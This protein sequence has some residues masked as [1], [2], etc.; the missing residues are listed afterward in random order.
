M[1]KPILI[2][3]GGIGGMT[4]AL[5]LLQAGFAVEIHEQADR[6]GDVGAGIT[7]GKTASRG[8]YS[9]GLQQAI[10]D[11]ADIPQRSGALH[12]QTGELIVN[13]Q[14]GGA[15]GPRQLDQGGGKEPPWFHQLHRADLFTILLDAVNAADP[16]AMRLSRNFTHYE[17]GPDGVTAHF[18]DGSTA[19]GSA[20]IGA[21][22]IRSAVRTQ[23]FGPEEPRF[24][25]QVVY[26]FLIPI[27]RVR[28]YL[29]DGQ[30]NLFVGPERTVLRYIIRHGTVVN[31]VAFVKTDAWTGEGYSEQVTPEELLAQ[32]PGWHE[33]VLGLFRNAP[34]EGTAKWALYD[35]DPLPTWIDGRVAL[36]GDAAHPMLPFLGLGAAMGIED[37]VVMARALAAHP[38]DIPRAF[39]I[40]EG[41]RLERANKILLESRAQG[42]RFQSVH[43]EKFDQ[44]SRPA[45]NETLY[46]YD[47]A[48]VALEP[49]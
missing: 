27:D 8:L 3:G 19:E 31:G 12:Y 17:Q 40:Y 29:N 22:G 15:A 16:K 47:P 33:N 25:G 48:T 39:K 7:L 46:D 14:G 1:T 38:D 23:M 26:R 13:A 2:I 35:R 20:L 34:P 36:L 43:P 9:L 6:I 45:T 18:A 21:D 32:F 11:G 49:A 37:G 24:T 5:A 42:E 30:S 41:A 28:Q 10:I 44:S 4:A